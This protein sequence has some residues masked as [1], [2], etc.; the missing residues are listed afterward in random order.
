MCL[1]VSFVALCCVVLCG[2]VCVRVVWCVC[3]CGVVCVCVWCVVCVVCFCIGFRMLLLCVFLCVFDSCFVSCL[4]LNSMQRRS[5]NLT[6][7][8]SSNAQARWKLYSCK[9]EATVKAKA[10][11]QPNSRSKKQRESNSPAKQADASQER[12]KKIPCKKQEKH[13]TRL[14]KCTALPWRGRTWHRKDVLR[15]LPLLASLAAW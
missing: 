4:A 15:P 8:R 14:A 9:S 13:Y 11:Q 12:A 6:A 10:W 3:V 1:F 2:V 7:L 5:L